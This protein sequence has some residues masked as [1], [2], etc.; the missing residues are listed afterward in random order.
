[1]HL[2]AFSHLAEAVE[3]QIGQRPQGCDEKRVQAT[4]IKAG[5]ASWGVGGP[6]TGLLPSAGALCCVDAADAQSLV[7]SLLLSSQSPGGQLG[8]LKTGQ[9]VRDPA[10]VRTGGN[11][12]GRPVGEFPVLA[13]GSAS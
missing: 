10:P 8:P 7:T 13:A 4:C 1:M 9:R 2:W 11:M 5:L 3:G 6:W 12:A